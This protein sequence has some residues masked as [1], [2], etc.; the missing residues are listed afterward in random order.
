MS[1]WYKSPAFSGRGDGSVV[2]SAARREAISPG[3][4]VGLRSTFSIF[5]VCFDALVRALW[6]LGELRKPMLRR[7]RSWE[8]E[9]ISGELDGT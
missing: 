9:T 8:M 3:S 5:I 4:K 7:R 2:R 6:I 1:Q